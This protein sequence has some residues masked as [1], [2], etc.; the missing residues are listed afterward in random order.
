M[1]PCMTRP[2]DI[3]PIRSATA[4]ALENSD[5]QKQRASGSLLSVCR[6]VFSVSL[7]REHLADLAHVFEDV[8]RRASSRVSMHVSFTR[9]RSPRVL[10]QSI[11][12]KFR[13]LHAD[14]DHHAHV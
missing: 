3:F 12:N 13:A 4:A 9:A 14:H 2:G 6:H 1:I 8:H 7:T 11:C 10:R 5:A